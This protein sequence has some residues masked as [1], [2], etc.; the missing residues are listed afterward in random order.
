MLLAVVSAT[1]GRIASANPVEGRTIAAKA[2]AIAVTSAL[3]PST[4][5]VV[6]RER[7]NGAPDPIVSD[8]GAGMICGPETTGRGAVVVGEGTVVQ[9]ATNSAGTSRTER[10]IS[11]LQLVC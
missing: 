2:W 8:E 4:T 10:D 1:A 3:L 6:R 5:I 7:S 11:A 9:A